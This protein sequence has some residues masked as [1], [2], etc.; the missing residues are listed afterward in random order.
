[1]AELEG[2]RVV[3]FLGLGLDGLRDLIPVVARIAAP[4]AGGAVDHLSAL[5]RVVVHALGAGDHPGPLLEGAVRRE[6]KPPSLEVVRCEGVVGGSGYLGGHGLS[7]E[8]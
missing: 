2:G 7:P 4:E 8:I 6:R 3:E 5:G 1:M